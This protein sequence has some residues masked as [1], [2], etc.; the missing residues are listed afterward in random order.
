M[1]DL[2]K[3]LREEMRGKKEQEWSGK[4]KQ[5]PLP[6]KPEQPREDSV[7]SG[8]NTDKPETEMKDL[9]PPAEVVIEKRK[10]WKNKRDKQQK[11]KRSTWHRYPS[12]T[13]VE[14]AAGIHPS[15]PR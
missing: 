12:M 4:R 7:I 13:T 6:K 10:K 5:A 2:R 1:E 8:I 14:Q 15:G 9:P 11:E 3:E